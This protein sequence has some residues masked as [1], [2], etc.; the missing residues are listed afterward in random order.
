VIGG[1]LAEPSKHYPTVFPGSGFWARYPYFLP[2]LVVVILLGVTLLTGFFFFEETLPE[3]AQPQEE[4]GLRWGRQFC[5]L[6]K[7]P[8]FTPRAAIRRSP[9]D[10]DVEMHNEG[11]SPQQSRET[12]SDNN[13]PV[14]E[15]ELNV[16]DPASGTRVITKQVV[17]Q[18]I[19]VSLLAFHK[20]A[21]DIIAPIFLASR[22][23][24]Q[25]RITIIETFLNLAAV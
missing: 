23:A 10:T 16:Q 13:I 8:V 9:Q 12:H 19:S 6:F 20:V 4:L 17:L 15:N 3:K 14:F 11:H 1:F 25:Q 7:Y 5:G 24:Q 18:I 21:S 2:N 22:L